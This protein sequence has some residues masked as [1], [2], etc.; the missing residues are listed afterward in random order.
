MPLSILY[1]DEYLLAVDKPAGL[2]VHPSYGHKSGTLLNAL[3]HYAT[4]WDAGRPSLVHRLDKQTSGVLLVAK[5]REAHRALAAAMAHTDA[6]K[7]YL[8]LCYGRMSRPRRLIR[9]PLGRDPRDRRR[10]I[11]RADG[12][13]AVTEVTRIASSRGAARGL[14]LVRCRLRTG[15]M[16]QIRVHLQAEGLPVVGDPVY[17]EAG[18]RRVG[19]AW[20]AERLRAF[21]HQA[22]HAWRLVVNHPFAGVRQAA[23]KEAG[24]LVPPLTIEAPIPADML[25]LL[26]HAGL[27]ECDLTVNPSARNTPTG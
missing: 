2:I 14:T 21:Q 5:S 24:T 8:A 6:R 9:W 7:E 22:L 15:R 16:H 19:D 25:Q 18:W 27:A 26:E 3:A 12:S 17:G 4:S 20:L 23:Q 11:V 13:G 10:V 1:E